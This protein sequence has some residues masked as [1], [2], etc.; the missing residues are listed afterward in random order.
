VD[1]G[2][3]CKVARIFGFWNYFPMGKVVDSVHGS[4]DHMGWPV[5]SST[6]DST[7]ANGRGLSELGLTAALGRGDLP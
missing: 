3:I 2:L 7:V 1:C 4:M 6:V 5:Q